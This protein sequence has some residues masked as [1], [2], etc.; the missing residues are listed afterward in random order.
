MEGTYVLHEHMF[1]VKDE[2]LK[3]QTLRV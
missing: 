3:G 2:Q 1:D